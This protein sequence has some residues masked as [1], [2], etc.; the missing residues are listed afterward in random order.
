MEPHEDEPCRIAVLLSE[1][2]RATI[3]AAVQAHVAA[4]MALRMRVSAWRISRRGRYRGSLSG[5][6]PNKQRDFDAG[7][8]NIV[9]DY[10]AVN[11]Q[12]PVYNEH[13]FETR[14]RVPRAVFRRVYSEVKDTPFF[15][16]RITLLAARRRTLYKR[17]LLPSVCSRMGRRQTAPT[18]TCG[19]PVQPSSFRSSVW[20]HASC[21]NG[22][23]PTCG[24]PTTR[25]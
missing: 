17:W 14:F 1:D 25:S 24:G 10:F 19:F 20:W 7:L 21:L 23:L 6:R 12:D 13:D 18:S 16:R 9:R 5:R 3:C 8:N 4:V 2:D 22:S 11:G 15:R